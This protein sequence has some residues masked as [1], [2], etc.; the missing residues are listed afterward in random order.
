M[1]VPDGGVGVSHARVRFFPVDEL[2][3]RVIA[4]DPELKRLLACNI[5]LAEREC[6]ASKL[7]RESL[8][9]D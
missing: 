2:Y 7:W 8:A 6:L 9:G 4:R 5:W 3:R 1:P